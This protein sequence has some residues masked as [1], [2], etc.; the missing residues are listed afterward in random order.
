MKHTRRQRV[1]VCV[2]YS[3]RHRSQSTA[4]PVSPVCLS[5]SE[6]SALC[7]QTVVTDV[8][9]SNVSPR[10]G[11][12][13]AGGRVLYTSTDKPPTGSRG[14]IN[15]FMVQGSV[16]GLFPFWTLTT[17]T[18]TTTRRNEASFTALKDIGGG[19]EEH[20]L[21]RMDKD[22]IFLSATDALTTCGAKQFQCGNRRCITTRWVCDGTDDCGDGTDELPATCCECL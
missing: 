9:F 14:L 7:V 17:T 1:C 20:H 19:G 15:S 18:T 21:P 3:S 8:V 13:A 2:C 22:L 11:R 16:V 10:S 5:R 6:L 12:A 4:M